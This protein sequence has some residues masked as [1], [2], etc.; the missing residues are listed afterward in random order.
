MD[1]E[2]GREIGQMLVILNRKK[3][4]TF[5]HLKVQQHLF[6][7]VSML[8]HRTLSVY[9]SVGNYDTLY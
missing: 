2:R 5:I 4:V 7:L 8:A 3:A 1:A 6:Q 9:V